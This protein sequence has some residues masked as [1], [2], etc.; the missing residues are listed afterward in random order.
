VNTNPSIKLLDYWK[1][2][3]DPVVLEESEL[4]Q[5]SAG[6]TFETQRTNREVL[7]D[8]RDP[9]SEGLVSRYVDEWMKK[10]VS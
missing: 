8:L 2:K 1:S 9:V 4:E 10:W 3:Y 5:R 7:A 6:L